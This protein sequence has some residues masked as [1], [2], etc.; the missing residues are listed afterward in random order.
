MIVLTVN[1]C[2]CGQ[3]ILVLRKK[4]TRDTCKSCLNKAR[5][6]KWRLTNPDRHRQLN[7]E[8]AA[9]CSEHKNAYDKQYREKFPEKST[10]R[11]R[12]FR[13]K[14]PERVNEIRRNYYY[15]HRNEEIQRVVERNKKE[16]T[17]KWANIN[18]ISDIYERSR[19]LTKETGV[20]HHVDH[21]IPLR[22]RNVSGLHVETNL[23]ILTRH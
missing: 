21:I 10:S 18:I 2:S 15:N 3:E 22:G 23:Q 13:E 17:P 12:R 14:N 6:I 16:R 9:R 8:S 7:R 5:I 1:I 19:I 4:G 11:M 20:V